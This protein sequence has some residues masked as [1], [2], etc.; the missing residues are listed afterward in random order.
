MTFIQLWKRLRRHPGAVR[1]SGPGSG[2]VRGEGEQDRILAA[3]AGH[4]EAG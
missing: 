1:A 4:E 2:S 3:P